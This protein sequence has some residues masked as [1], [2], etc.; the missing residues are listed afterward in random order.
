MEPILVSVIMPI[1]KTNKQYLIEAIDSILNQ[2]YKTFELLLIIDE[3]PE[4]GTK[5]I[6]EKKEDD[7]III[8]ENGQNKGLVYSLNKGLECAKG[9]YIFRMDSDD[10]ALE[11][12]LKKQ[13]E[14]FEHHK[15]GV[16]LG[17]YAKTFGADVKEFKSSTSDAQIK[18]ELIWKNPIVHPTVAFRA[19]FI[20]KNNIRYRLGDSE[21]YRLWIELAFKYNCVFAVLPEI[22][23]KYR[24]HSEQITY[25]DREKILDMEKNIVKLIL[26]YCN[27]ELEEK[28]IDLFCTIKQGTPIN[29]RGFFAG[30]RILKKID[31]C[32][33]NKITKDVLKKSYI[34]GLI[35][36]LR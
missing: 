3:D 30:L 1:Y 16:V 36:I 5:K 8:I 25:R 12:R 34:K 20:K 14:Y 32:I 6:L 15:E 18:G 33:D 19:S 13:I 2:S 21:D 22:L 17:T 26:Q 4:L 27:I 35:K 23:L 24:V 11:H 31:K 29:F 7:R 28:E 10:I 9:K